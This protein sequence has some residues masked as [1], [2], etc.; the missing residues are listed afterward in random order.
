M[1]KPSVA[2]LLGILVCLMGITA[3]SR[4]VYAEKRYVSAY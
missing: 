4:C 1:K 2:V 3:G